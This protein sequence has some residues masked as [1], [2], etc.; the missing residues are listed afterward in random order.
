MTKNTASDMVGFSLL[1]VRLLGLK[2]KQILL[3]VKKIT[4]LLFILQHLIK[5]SNNSYYFI[6]PLHY[7]ICLKYFLMN[8]T[9]FKCGPFYVLA[10]P[11]KLARVVWG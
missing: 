8:I 10:S 9:I 2:S 11:A 4:P 3:K 6:P 1:V 7:E 5:L